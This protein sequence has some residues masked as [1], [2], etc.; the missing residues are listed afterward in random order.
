MP[1]SNRRR[2]VMRWVK[3]LVLVYAVLGIA[4][5]YG[6]EKLLFHPVP[7]PRSTA[8]DF[9]QRMIER[10]IPYD[11]TTNLNVV[12]FQATDRPEDS[13]ARGVVLYFHGNKE[14]ISRYAVAAKDFTSKGY[15]VWMLDYPGFGKSTGEFSEKKLY[16]YSLIFYKL[17]RSR[18]QPGQIILYGKS[19]GTGVAAQLA[20]VRDC[21]RLVLETPYYSLESLARR[22]LFMYPVGMMLHYHFPTYQYLPN[23]TAPIT[24]FQGDA[25]KTVPYGNAARLK[26][27]LKAGDEFVTV[28]DGQHND[29]RDHAIFKAKLDSVLRL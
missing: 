23:V 7:V 13:L 14:G 17:A 1:Q 6:Q 4:W 12:Q 20:S 15:E 8:Y 29:L 3:V 10:N 25:D 22:F 5:Y 21:R 16:E 2:I 28:P 9:G 27:F 11:K 19:L 26:V 24:I 18:W